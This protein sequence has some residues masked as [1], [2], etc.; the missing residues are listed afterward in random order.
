MYYQDRNIIAMCLPEG[1]IAYDST[2]KHEYGHY[3]YFKVLT[4]EQREAYRKLW[5]RDKAYA[6]RFSR[7]YSQVNV[8]EGFADDYAWSYFRKY[9]PKPNKYAVM[10]IRLI[11]SF[12]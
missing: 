3:V 12:K 11:K 1:T 6:G 8:Y 9:L 5:E 2:F 4:P 10:R 7:T